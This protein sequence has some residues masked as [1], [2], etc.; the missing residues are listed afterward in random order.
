MKIEVVRKG[1]IYGSKEFF[2]G[3]KGLPH[4]GPFNYQQ[5]GYSLRVVK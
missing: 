3:L 2:H 5:D 1:S 4:F